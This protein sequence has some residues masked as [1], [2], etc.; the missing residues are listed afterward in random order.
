MERKSIAVAIILTRNFTFTIS[1]GGSDWGCMGEIKSKSTSVEIRLHLNSTLACSLG[2]FRFRLTMISIWRP[3][4]TSGS[5]PFGANDI[6]SD[7]QRGGGAVRETHL[8]KE[9]P[10][11]T[12][13]DRAMEEV[14]SQRE[15][16]WHTQKRKLKRL[17]LEWREAIERGEELLR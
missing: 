15:L 4:L 2:R 8:R 6:P 1:H 16:F 10:M 3:R 11:K 12:G 17:P 5:A 13:F 14:A 7:N 9:E